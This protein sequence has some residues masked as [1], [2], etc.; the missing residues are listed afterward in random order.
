[1]EHAIAKAELTELSHIDM[2][3]TLSDK[4][5]HAVARMVNVLEFTQGCV[6]LSPQSEGGVRM[7]GYAEMVELPFACGWCTHRVRVCVTS[8]VRAFGIMCP[9]C[10]RP[11][12]P[13]PPTFPQRTTPA[14]WQCT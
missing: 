13:L 3:E 7:S 9:M 2:F 11:M 12:Y 14:W 8:A 10:G 1:M 6:I 5:L 4:D